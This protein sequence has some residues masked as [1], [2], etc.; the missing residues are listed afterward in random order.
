M[1]STA[2]RY[3]GVF[4]LAM[5]AGMVLAWIMVVVFVPATSVDTAFTILLAAGLAGGVIATA[6]HHWKRRSDA[7]H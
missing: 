2:L 6:L 7:S 3:A 4:L 1:Q 5:F